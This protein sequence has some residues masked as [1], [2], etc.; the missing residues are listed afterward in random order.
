[1]D[2]NEDASSPK[3]IIELGSVLG[4]ENYDAKLIPNVA[5]MLHPLNKLL[6]KD[7]AWK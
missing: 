7:I 2:T 1:M 4:L 6:R 3:N 5:M